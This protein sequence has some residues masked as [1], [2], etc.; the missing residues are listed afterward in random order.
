[1]D[2]E[3]L[4]AITPTTLPPDIVMLE[5]RSNTKL[6]T[7]CPR[8]RVISCECPEAKYSIVKGLDVKGYFK[9]LRKDLLYENAT[10]SELP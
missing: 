3:A 6:N 7:V 4:E 5:L 9:F 8:S 10:C 2:M 1:M